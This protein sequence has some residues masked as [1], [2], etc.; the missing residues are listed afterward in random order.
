MSDREKHGPQQCKDEWL[1]LD[2]ASLG[3]HLSQWRNPKRSTEQFEQFISTQLRDSGRAM[4]LGC[5]AGAAT[6]YIARRHDQVH[7]DLSAPEDLDVMGIFTVRTAQPQA[8]HRNGC[9]LAGR[10]S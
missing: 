1:K 5:G 7:I 9:S 4:D 2:D 3:Y 10:S 6:A 8:R